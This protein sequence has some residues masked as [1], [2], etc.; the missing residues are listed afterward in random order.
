MSKHLPTDP[1]TELLFSTEQQ[2]A[3]WSTL[4]DTIM[5]GTSK[6]VCTAS[7]EG[8]LIEGFLVEEAGG[9]V[10][11]RSPLLDPPI[12]LS[13]F[14]GLNLEIDG[15]GRTLK[16][17]LSCKHNIFGIPDFLGSSLRWITLIPTNT[18][19]T[20]TVNISFEDL[21]PTVR[22]K[23]VFLPY[24]FDPSGVSEFQLL[25]SKFGLPGELNPEFKAGMIKVLLRSISGI[26]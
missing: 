6:A 5:G 8:L 13:K 15:N 20:S 7:Q 25:Y 10:S 26:Y 12:N 18:Y 24:K 21:Y 3:Q 9:F 19:G 2:F 14:Q 4:N 1:S 11:C 22:A 23:P 17:A 16:L